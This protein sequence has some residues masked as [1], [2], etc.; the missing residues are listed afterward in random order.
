MFPQSIWVVADSQE[1]LE[2]HAIEAFLYFNPLMPILSHLITD[3]FSSLEIE[4]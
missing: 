2:D 4:F 3:R 1:I